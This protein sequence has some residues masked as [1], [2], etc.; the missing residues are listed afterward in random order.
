MTPNSPYSDDIREVCNGTIELCVCTLHNTSSQQAHI[1]EP[2]VNAANTHARTTVVLIVVHTQD[3][4]LVNQ[5]TVCVFIHYCCYALSK[6][7]INSVLLW[8]SL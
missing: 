3:D 8:M 2:S 5:R 6:Y 7:T 1:R 4:L